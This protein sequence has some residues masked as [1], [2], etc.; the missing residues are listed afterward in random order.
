MSRDRIAAAALVLAATSCVIGPPYKAPRPDLPGAWV[1]TQTVGQTPPAAYDRWWT[2]FDDPELDAL[3]DRAVRDNLDLQIAAARVRESRAAEGIAASA[4]SPQ[5][6]ASGAY[7]R[8]ERS[9]AVPP[10]KGGTSGGNVFGPRT[11]GLFQIGFDAGWEIDV[12]GGVRRDREAAAAQTEAEEEGERDVLVS[13]IGDVARHYVELR[14]TQQQIEILDAT[15]QSEQDTL[16]LVRARYD[17]GLGGDLDVERAAGLL[18]ATRGRRPELER[19]ARSHIHRLGVLVGVGAGDLLP[20]L[21]TPRPLPPEPPPPPVSV[22][23]ELLWR[24]PD[25]RRAEREIAAATAR[26]GVARADL[27]P[28]FSITG[29]FGRRSEESSDLGA[30]T[31]QYWFVAPAIRWPVLSGGRIRANIRVHEA[32]QEAALARYE[33]AV[34]SAIEEVEN[35]LSA[36]VREHRR[37]GSLRESVAANR[38]ALDLATERYTSGLESFLSVLDAQRAVYAAEETLAEGE[39]NADVS[40]IAVYKALGGGLPSDA[41][42]P[43]AATRGRR[44][45]STP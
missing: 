32:R 13:L 6:D 17:A 12:F 8:G 30:S 2:A 35:A 1:E 36:E 38:R 22:P 19:A 21:D 11:Q 37:L 34:L 44:E 41:T 31:S 3:I 33:K 42:I 16:D 25:L 4:G 5:V 18:E 27:F 9:E 7:V 39:T 14:G 15:L 24:R 45:P 29:S 28:R 23:S 43:I 10:F 26:I 20:A 40:V